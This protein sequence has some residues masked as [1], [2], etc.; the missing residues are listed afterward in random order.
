M[1]H[2]RPRGHHTPHRVRQTR[3]PTE[4]RPRCPNQ[5]ESRH[6]RRLM[7]L[8]WPGNSPPQRTHIGADPKP[9]AST[10]PSVLVRRSRRSRPDHRDRAEPNSPR[11]RSVGH[12][13]HLAGLLSRPGR[14]TTSA[15]PPSGSENPPASIDFDR[16]AIARIVAC[17]SG[18][19]RETGQQRID[20][21]DTIC[22][23]KSWIIPVSHEKCREPDA[24]LLKA[25]Y[26]EC[27]CRGRNRGQTET[28][29]VE[30]VDTL[31]PGRSVAERTAIGR[32]KNPWPQRRGRTRALR[33]E[34]DSVV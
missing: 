9:I 2:R 6:A 22:G 13:G 27:V 23:I 31:K 3:L 4:R 25:I 34:F 20:S 33:S 16:P 18:H 12:R 11:R 10:S 7:T 24:R 8:P 14:L 28:R 15:S 19:Q 26:G 5:P 32:G 17:R 1:T 29:H 30:V 21:S